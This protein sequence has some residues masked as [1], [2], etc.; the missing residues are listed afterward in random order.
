MA[1]LA[2]GESGRQGMGI[3]MAG[4]KG[5][6]ELWGN[7]MPTMTV[8][9]LLPSVRLLFFYLRGNHQTER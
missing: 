2:Y 3:T 8:G 5:E 7:W 1:A 4:S 6:R 9:C